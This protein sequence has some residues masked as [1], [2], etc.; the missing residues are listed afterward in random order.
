VEMENCGHIPRFEEPG[1]LYTALLE[2]LRLR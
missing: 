2:F 1:E